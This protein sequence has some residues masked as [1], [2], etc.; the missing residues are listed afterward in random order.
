MLYQYRFTSAAKKAD[1]ISFVAWV[2]MPYASSSLKKK[3]FNQYELQVDSS[4]GAEG[5]GPREGM[6]FQELQQFSTYL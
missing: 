6:K 3:H 5:N 4:G 2:D 1:S